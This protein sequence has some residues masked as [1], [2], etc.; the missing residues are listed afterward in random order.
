MKNVERDEKGFSS[1][2]KAFGV[3]VKSRQGFHRAE[4]Q[5]LHFRFK[6]DSLLMTMGECRSRSSA[7]EA[8]MGKKPVILLEDDGVR[9][10]SVPR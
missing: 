2:L 9:V 10:T 7:V 1:L 5:V 3:I 8:D 4:L 6:I